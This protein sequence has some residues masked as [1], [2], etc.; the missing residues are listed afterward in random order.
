MFFLRLEAYVTGSQ[1]A[2]AM[3]SVLYLPILENDSVS[4]LV[5]NDFDSGLARVIG[6]ERGSQSAEIP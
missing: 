5:S 3:T 2:S 6:G 4:E 1:P